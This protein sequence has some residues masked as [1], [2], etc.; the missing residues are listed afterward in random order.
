M[1]DPF[2]RC[3][4]LF[5]ALRLHAGVFCPS[6]GLP[7][8][9]LHMCLVSLVADVVRVGEFLGSVLAKQQ[10]LLLSLRWRPPAKVAVMVQE[11]MVSSQKKVDEKPDA[12]K[13]LAA[14]HE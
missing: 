3:D 4:V 5:R 14:K 12:A 10:I 7:V 6:L 13:R 1:P 8:S 2:V 9:C 11:S